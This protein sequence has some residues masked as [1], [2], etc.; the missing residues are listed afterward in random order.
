MAF[1]LTEIAV[2]VNAIGSV[3][4]SHR[5]YEFSL[6]NFIHTDQVEQPLTY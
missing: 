5:H 1:I 2:W 6:Y 4:I 3:Q